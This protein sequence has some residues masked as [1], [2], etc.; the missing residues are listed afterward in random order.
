LLKIA[1][2]S[3]ELA[4]LPDL[5]LLVDHC[6]NLIVDTSQP[7]AFRVYAMDAVYRACLEEPLLKNELKVVLELLPAD[8]PISVRSRA[9]NVLK[10]LS[11]KKR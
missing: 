4:K 3:L 7:Y 10:K 1:S 11:G 2:E 8:S 6:F 9:K 5:G